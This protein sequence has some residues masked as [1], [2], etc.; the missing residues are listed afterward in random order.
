MTV[1]SEN[2]TACSGMELDSGCLYAQ[3][4]TNWNMGCQLQKSGA[5]NTRMQNI[6]WPR[7]CQQTGPYLWCFSRDSADCWW[8]LRTSFELRGEHWSWIGIPAAWRSSI[9]RR[10]CVSSW[11]NKDFL[12]FFLTKCWPNPSFR[13]VTFI[14]RAGMKP[15]AKMW[16]QAKE[17]RFLHF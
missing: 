15:G 10:S 8:S 6:H 7:S 13:K 14:T 12:R 4:D 5:N 16:T 2:S 3:A 9:S 17:I 1:P 11:F